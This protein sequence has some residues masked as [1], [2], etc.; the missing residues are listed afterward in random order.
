MK[1]ELNHQRTLWDRSLVELA[2]VDREPE[3]E[4]MEFLRLGTTTLGCRGLDIGCGL[5]RHTAAALRLG[6]D[7]TAIDFSEIAVE[8]TKALAHAEGFE[9]EVRCASMHRLPFASDQFDF[10]FSWCVL[11]HGTRAVFEAALSEALRV[12]RRD[13]FFFG[14]VMSQNDPRY[15]HGIP[16]EENCFAF[17]EGPEAGVCHY[18]PNRADLLTALSRHAHVEK[19]EEVSFGGEET[20]F[21]HPEMK[22][23][24]HFSFVARK[25]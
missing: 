19:L 8:G 1:F 20:T 7:M 16:I 17:S 5:G 2:R 13:G 12:V 3:P 10:A 22:H 25:T 24:C 9:V 6:Y 23:S 14:F 18:F 21:Y 15:G 4:L 11:N